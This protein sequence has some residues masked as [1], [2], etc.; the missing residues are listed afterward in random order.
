MN[1]KS[2]FGSVF[3]RS[4]V[5]RKPPLLHVFELASRLVL[6]RR[7]AYASH[8]AEPPSSGCAAPSLRYG[9][10]GMTAPRRRGKWHP[11]PFG[12]RRGLRAAIAHQKDMVSQSHRRAQPSRPA[13]PPAKRVALTASTAMAAGD[14]I[15]ASIRIVTGART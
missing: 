14:V 7:T 6:W 11:C 2:R 13:K 15:C 1:R 5:A 8:A 3:G 4:I 10:F 9:P 12:A